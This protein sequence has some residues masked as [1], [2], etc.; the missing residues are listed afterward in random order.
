M[1]GNVNRWE[2]TLKVAP[3][4]WKR[5]KLGQVFTQ[6]REQGFDDLPL[7]SVTGQEGVIPRDELNRRDTSSEDKSKY[8]RVL[9]GDIVYNTMRMWQGVNALSEYEGIVSPAYTVCTPLEGMDPEYAKYLFK[10]PPL[11]TIFWRYSQGIVDD[12]LGLKFPGFANINAV[13]PPVGIQ[14]KIAAILSSVDAAIERTRAVIEQTR[15]VKQALLQD[16]LTH[17]LPG[18]HK[19]FKTDPRLGRI[20]AEWEVVKLGT[21][22]LKPEYGIS[23][24]LEDTGAIPIL[25]MQNLSDGEV[26]LSDLKFS[27]NGDA[28]KLLLKPMDILFNRTNSIDH[29][30]RTAIWRGQ[31]AKT[32]FA[33]YLVRLRAKTDRMHPE[34]LNLIMNTPLVQMRIKR[35]ATPGVQQVN[36]NPTSLRSMYILRPML[37]EQEAIIRIYNSSNARLRAEVDKL[38]QFQSLK[39][40]LSQ[41]LLTGQIPVKV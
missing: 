1:R 2:D 21:V 19:R 18:R 16:L 23:S 41:G 28:E 37:D 36:V 32:S 4:S 27:S 6:R 22:T 26:V 38:D 33:S 13:L 10:H 29:V 31:H 8:Q 3:S 24:S 5:V 35:L 20:P 40:A 30:G 39:T 9:P 34:F 25:R 11:V 14:R 17:G 15:V 7:L 12:T